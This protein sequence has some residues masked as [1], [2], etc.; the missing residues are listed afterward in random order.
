MDETLITEALVE[1]IVKL[2]CDGRKRFM[3]ECFIEYIPA[4]NAWVPINA[5]GYMYID[6]LWVSGSFKG[7]GYSTPR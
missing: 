3:R 1:E 7:K 5:D 6:C 4:E 2:L